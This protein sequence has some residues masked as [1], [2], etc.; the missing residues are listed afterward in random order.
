MSSSVLHAL[1]LTA[2][3]AA[4][5]AAAT[6]TDDNEGIRTA[7]ASSGLSVTGCDDV[8][9]TKRCSNANVNNMCCAACASASPPCTEDDH[10]GFVAHMNSTV[11]YDENLSGC[12]DAP[13]CSYAITQFCCGTCADA[14]VTIE[15]PWADDEDPVHVYLSYGQSNC[16]GSASARLMKTD[17]LHPELFEN[18]T[19]KS[20][21]WLAGLTTRT[22]PNGDSF[23]ISASWAGCLGDTHGP[24]F[25]YGN[26]LQELTGN[27]VLIF[28]Y[29]T[30]GTSAKEDWNPNWGNN[31]W[32]RTKD[33]GT[34]AFLKDRRNAT[35]QKH[36]QYLQST[37]NLRLLREQLNA[38]GVS[39]EIKGIFWRQGSAD[40]S[41]DWKTYG[42]NLIRMFNA[43][44]AEVGVPDLPIIDEGD[45]GRAHLHGGKV[46]AAKVLCHATVG[47][48]ITSIQNDSTLELCQPRI[49]DACAQYRIYSGE[50]ENQFGWPF[51]FPEDYKVPKPGH[52]T[53][54]SKWVVRFSRDPVTGK[55]P[56][57]HDEY[58]GMWW[59][60]I[61][62]ANAYVREHTTHTVPHAMT[63]W[64]TWAKWPGK[65]C[66][67][68]S[69]RSATNFCWED[70]SEGCVDATGY[71]S[72]VTAESC[73]AT[74]AHYIN[75]PCAC[76]DVASCTA[77]PADIDRAT[78]TYWPDV[79]PTGPGDSTTTPG[80]TVSVEATTPIATTSTANPNCMD[81]NVAII[82]LAARM[83]V[84]IS[85]C[86]NKR[87]KGACSQYA[88]V[89]KHC[90]L[91]CQD[92]VPD[93]PPG[94]GGVAPAKALSGNPFAGTSTPTPDS[95]TGTK[96]G[97]TSSCARRSRGLRRWFPLAAAGV[98]AMTM[99]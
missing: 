42:A 14:N 75:C 89:L 62:M 37:Y 26:R 17:G 67:A 36:E 64:D 57:L 35:N 74:E 39:Y 79:M 87:V 70:D 22:E 85:G 2:V 1:L 16:Q 3:I 19:N 13:S 61:A 24:E 48:S 29:C 73:R 76:Q 98:A 45:S 52:S 7:F 77:E 92:A 41:T 40:Q 53:A 27:R 25:A 93:S 51:G 30:G 63:E 34:A 33:N 50:L 59:N 97:D 46:Y 95:T 18:D 56:N 31:K 8:K 6:C 81:D 54:T 91:T 28:K 88:V 49:A 44:R 4:A 72:T 32:D 99:C 15:V 65:R 5:T 20:K 38:S 83:N 82:A 58:G 94:P 47:V 21:V 23:G 12:A 11:G 90:C 71:C 80:T 96:G 9:V 86:D 60:G 43:M 78:L 55:N 84:T 10:E 68:D 66:T 69:V